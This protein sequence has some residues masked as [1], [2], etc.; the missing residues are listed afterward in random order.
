MQFKEF[1]MPNFYIGGRR[2][3]VFSKAKSKSR[4]VYYKQ[5]IRENILDVCNKL[6]VSLEY[7]NCP[8]CHS[9][10]KVDGF[11]FD[12]S[13]GELL[14][15][16]GKPNYRMVI[17]SNGYKIHVFIYRQVIK[18]PQL[19][20][21]Y[22]VNGQLIFSE[23]YFEFPD[24]ELSKL[25]KKLLIDKYQLPYSCDCNEAVIVDENDNVLQ[26]KEST[27][28]SIKYFGKTNFSNVVELNSQFENS[29]N[30]EEILCSRIYE[31]V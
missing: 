22:F 24:S 9:K 20:T 10:I 18:K 3:V 16:K 6:K 27:F 17:K 21:F 26:I 19:R 2:S 11:D 4:N 15:S 5:F 31:C 7:N 13:I 25:V 14:K 29:V 12:I 30:K 8:V 28:L 23:N 1:I